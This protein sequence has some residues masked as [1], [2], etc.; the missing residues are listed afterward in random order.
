MSRR[1]AAR[2]CGVERDRG[3]SPLG[4]VPWLA[5][6]LFGGWTMWWIGG[7]LQTAV[8]NQPWSEEAVVHVSIVNWM[9]T[10]E[11]KLVPGEKNFWFRKV[12]SR[13]PRGLPAGHT[14]P[15]RY[16]DLA[17]PPQRRSGGS[18]RRMK[19][20][21][22]GEGGRGGTSFRDIANAASHLTQ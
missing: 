8:D 21:P 14:L 7:R 20:A 3:G 16:A 9:K 15:G 22:A 17:V 6:T 5:K 12:R 19:K 4:A 11:A 2:A 10:R 13:R 18:S 1:R